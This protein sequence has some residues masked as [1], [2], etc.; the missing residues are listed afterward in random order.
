MRET[1]PLSDKAF[2]GIDELIAKADELVALGERLR[3]ED[4]EPTRRLHELLSRNDLMEAREL[5][6]R[7]AEHVPQ[8]EFEVIQ[9]SLN[10]LV[11]E[12]AHG[13]KVDPEVIAEI[14][15]RIKELPRLAEMRHGLKSRADGAGR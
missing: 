3:A 11:S 15:G 2:D 14:V 13:T 4:D 7:Y 9:R 10:A 5:L 1:S 6:V 8:A 12:M